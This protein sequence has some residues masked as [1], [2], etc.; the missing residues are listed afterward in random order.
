VHFLRVT[1]MDPNEQK[2]KYNLDSIFE[3][4]NPSKLNRSE[5]DHLNFDEEEALQVR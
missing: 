5:L 4:S 1:A 3:D 2:S